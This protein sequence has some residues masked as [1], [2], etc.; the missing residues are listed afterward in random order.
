VVS[1]WPGVLEMVRGEQGLAVGKRM[2]QEKAF[3]HGREKG[4][5]FL[6]FLA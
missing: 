5:R 3:K 2:G 6:S 1:E 4:V